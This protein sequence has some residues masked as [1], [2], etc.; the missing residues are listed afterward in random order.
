MQQNKHMYRPKNNT[1][2]MSG[3]IVQPNQFLLGR[4]QIL[5]GQQFLSR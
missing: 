3:Q 4:K 5:S 1:C 2:E